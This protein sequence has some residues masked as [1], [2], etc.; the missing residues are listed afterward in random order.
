MDK[1][2]S[3]ACID[4]SGDGTPSISRIRS[5]AN[6]HQDTR[7]GDT[8]DR[9]TGAG[10]SLLPN[11]GVSPRG[12]AVAQACWFAFAAVFCVL[13]PGRTGLYLVLWVISA[14]ALIYILQ[15]LGGRP[16]VPIGRGTVEIGPATPFVDR[17]LHDGLS[18]FLFAFCAAVIAVPPALVHQVLH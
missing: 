18:I 8:D 15:R 17:L 13:R 10:W 5:L 16:A 3:P 11:L 7:S 14:V 9:P 12:E 2:R 4:L 1:A 6:D